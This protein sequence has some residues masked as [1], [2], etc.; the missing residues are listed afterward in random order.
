MDPYTGWVYYGD[1]GPDRSGLSSELPFEGS[2]G[3]DEFNQVKGPG[4][5]G[6]PYF[7][8]DNK[9]YRDGGDGVVGNPW[10][11]VLGSG[12]VAPISREDSLSYAT[13]I[14]LAMRTE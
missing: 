8:A 13:A 14:G 7:L 10:T 4:W 11:M 12:Q 3:H 9:A 2:R 6:W 5:F 1:V